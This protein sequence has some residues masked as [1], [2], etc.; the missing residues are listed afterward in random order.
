MGTTLDRS[1][2]R[3]CIGSR[4]VA[5]LLLVLVC[6]LAACESGQSDELAEATTTDAETYAA[7]PVADLSAIPV[8][9]AEDPDRR[10]GAAA[11][12]VECE[13]DLWQGGWSMDFGPLGSGPNPDAAIAAM[14]DSGLVAPPADEFVAVAQDE[15]RVVFSYEASGKPRFAVVVA[16]SEQVMAL[17]T[18]DRWAVEVFASC[19]PAEFDPSVDGR[20]G[21]EIWVDA[22]GERVPTSVL[23]VV[24]GPEHCD[25]ESVTF[26]NV[27]GASFVADSRGVLGEGH[28]AAPFDDD[29]ELPADAVETGYH[30]ESRRLW[31]ASDGRFAFVVDG[32]DVQAWPALAQPTACA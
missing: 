2:W 7:L 14:A 17:D 22:D 15:G 21:Y 30:R 29:A 23:A 6:G 1:G 11:D 28:V 8:A 10:A 4:S 19:D 25:W 9:D 18:A 31:L 5:G 3:R 16:D 20:F 27:E 12:F 24:N 13:H 26:L 32:D